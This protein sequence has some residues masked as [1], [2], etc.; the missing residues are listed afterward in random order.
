[1]RLDGDAGLHDELPSDDVGAFA[2]Q[3]WVGGSHIYLP[4]VPLG[5]LHRGVDGLGARLQD[6]DVAIVVGAIPRVGCPPQLD[7]HATHKTDDFFRRS[8]VVGWDKDGS[9]PTEINTVDPLKH[10]GYLAIL[11]AGPHVLLVRPC[12]DKV[13]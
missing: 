12:N 2:Q 11:E 7:K 1:M 5:V 9:A 3:S 10:E 6:L 13:S 8:R 4:V